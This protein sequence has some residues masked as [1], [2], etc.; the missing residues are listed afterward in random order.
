MNYR[1]AFHAG[2][3]ADVM[4]H[5][6]LALCLDRSTLRKRPSLYR[7]PRR[8]RP[9]LEG[10]EAARTQNGATASPACGKLNARAAEAGGGPVAERDPRHER[11][12]PADGL[13]W[14]ASACREADA[15]DGHA[16][17]CELHE[18]SAALLCEAMGRDRR[19]KIEERDGL[20][21]LPAYLPPPERRG[22]V[23]IDPPFEED[24]GAEARP[25]A[26]RGSQ[27]GA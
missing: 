14:L 24:R 12:R 17:L 22:L 13:S 3:F 4:K 21:A 19:V 27:P 25:S 23:L 1:H 7:Y 8:H 20:E 6:A 16:A 10:D 18:A 26:W 9:C 11:R 5:L 15:Q 2:N